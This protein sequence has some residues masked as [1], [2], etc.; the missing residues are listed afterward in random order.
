MAVSTDSYFSNS[1]PSGEM[2]VGAGIDLFRQDS[3]PKL[4]VGVLARRADGN[5]Y[6]YSHFGA[7]CTAGHVVSPDL[8]ESAY[9]YTANA[10]VATGSSFQQPDESNGTYPGMIGSRYVVVLLGTVAADTYAGG[11][12]D[13]AGGTG[14]G[15]TYRIKGNKASNGTATTLELY[16]PIKVGLDATSDLIV[17]PSLYA[18]L[19]HALYATTNNSVA[20]GVTVADITTAGNY[21]WILKEGVIGIRGYTAMGSETL[22]QGDMVTLSSANA[23][24][25]VSFG[26]GVGGGTA[27]TQSSIVNPIIGVCVL[28]VGANSQHILVKVKL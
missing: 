26:H 14:V 21:G 25:V 11:Y 7:A 10:V 15:Y 5:L 22:V 19:E 18:N 8:N 23:G 4:A 28:P 12:L 3:E 16:D 24:Q 1:L 9:I 13:I 27:P 2:T 6:V 20:V 17:G